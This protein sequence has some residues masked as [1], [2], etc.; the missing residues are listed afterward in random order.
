MKRTLCV[1]L[2]V[3]LC[4]VLCACG[5]EDTTTTAHTYEDLTIRLPADFIDLSDEA[6]A[7]G[8]AFL[9]GLD[10][11]AVNGLREEKALFASYG[12]ELD[13][14]RY[15]K[16]VV[17]SNNLTV[18]PEKKDGIL[19]FSYEAV[20]D[21]VSYTYVVTLRETADAFWTVQAYCPTADYSDVKDEIWD[22]LSSVT[23]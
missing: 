20:T 10:P 4:L 7:A 9:H 23:V 3:C 6:Y 22:I 1:F 12:L 19:T 21:G 11:L 13:L 5:K 8:L 17:L 14:E 2:A 15:A 18:Q 16:L